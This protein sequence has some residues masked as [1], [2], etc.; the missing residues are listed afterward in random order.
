VAVN[1]HLH[2][3]IKIFAEIVVEQYL[4]E[5]CTKPEYADAAQSIPFGKQPKHEDR[6]HE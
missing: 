4:R 3:I 6:I 2:G 5:H 1:E